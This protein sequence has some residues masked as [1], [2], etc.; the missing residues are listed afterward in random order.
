MLMEPQVA[1]MMQI[2]LMVPP[3]I[4]LTVFAFG[5]SQFHPQAPIAL[6][7]MGAPVIYPFQLYLMTS[8]GVAILECASME[9]VIPLLKYATL[10]CAASR[11]Q[12]LL[13]W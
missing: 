1:Q 4:Q 7:E 13:L 3:A 8:F 10:V 6:A 11:D 9:H 12:V 2:A 5:T